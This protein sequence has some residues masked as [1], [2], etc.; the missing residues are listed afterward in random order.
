MVVLAY[1]KRDPRVRREAEALANSGHLVDVISL[2]EGDEAKQEK[3]NGVSVHRCDMRRSERRGKLDLIVQYASFLFRSWWRLTR[4]HITES[5]DIAVVH[6][7]PNFLVFA[8][9]PWRYLGMKVVLDMH[10]PSPET[11][12]NLFGSRSRFFPWLMLFEERLCCAYSNRTMTVNET[13]R[14]IFSERTRVRPLVFHNTP[15]RSMYR[16]LKTRYVTSVAV[17]R[18]I[19]H[20]YLHPRDGIE[21]VIAVLAGLNTPRVRF[22]LDVYGDGP[23]LDSLRAMAEQLSATQWCHFHGRF[24][25]EQMGP[26]LAKADLAIATYLPDPLAHLR[27]PAKLLDS[28]AI[29]LPVIC[30]DL[31]AIRQYFDE[32]CVYFFRSEGELRECL[33]E[34]WADYAEARRRAGNARDR[35]SRILWDREAPTYV[36]FIETVASASS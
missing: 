27:L 6:N 19:I 1:Y 30:R 26:V 31:K 21:L 15:D 35:I 3:V 28:A 2:N 17:R 20:G 9:F 23:G 12:A 5:Y 7:M 4:M 22:L 14:I 33:L 36:E 29:G 25:S 24:I 32:D 34:V 16:E 10:D 8:T 18:I 11:F 13:I